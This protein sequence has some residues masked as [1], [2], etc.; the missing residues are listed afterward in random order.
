MRS[1]CWFLSVFT[2]C[3]WVEVAA[4]NSASKRCRFYACPCIPGMSGMHVVKVISIPT[5]FFLFISSSMFRLWLGV[6]T[7]LSLH[8]QQS[9]AERSEARAHLY[10]A[11]LRS[12]PFRYTS[13]HATSLCNVRALSR[14]ASLAPRGSALGFASRVPLCGCGVLRTIPLHGRSR[15]KRHHKRVQI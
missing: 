15:W 7:V 6:A 14:I 13:F 4:K 10:V 5:L 9:L 12:V 8:H 1:P 2:K 3:C 11:T